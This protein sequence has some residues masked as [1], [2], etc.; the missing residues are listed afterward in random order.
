MLTLTLIRRQVFPDDI[1]LLTFAKPAHLAWTAG[2]HIVMVLEHEN[3]DGHGVMRALSIATS[4]REDDIQIVTHCPERGSSFKR[5]LRDLPVGG[6][7]SA[8]SPEGSFVYKDSEL[9]A[10]FVAGGV[11]IGAIR[12]IL[13]DRHLAGQPLRGRLEYY[14]TVTPAVFADDL[15]TIAAAHPDFQ[16]VYRD[17]PHLQETGGIKEI[18]E[19]G[20]MLLYFSAVYS[21]EL[22]RAGQ[23][24]ERAEQLPH[25]EEATLLAHAVGLTH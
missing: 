20:D 1:H 15:H 21:Q 13:M 8:T 24:A 5:A 18:E 2:Q 25:H 7:V 6:A 23:A 19:N 9:P 17:L 3:P 10:L 11:G 4:P 22:L 14:S 12:A 16:I